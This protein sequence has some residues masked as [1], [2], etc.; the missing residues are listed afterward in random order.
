[1]HWIQQISTLKIDEMSGFWPFVKRVAGCGCLQ[2]Q[3]KH[4]KY[5]IRL[6]ARDKRPH[7]EWYF[8]RSIHLNF[9]NEIKKTL[10][11]FINRKQLRPERDNDNLSAYA[12]DYS[13]SLELLVFLRRSWATGRY[14]ETETS[15][16]KMKKGECNSFQSPPL[17][18]LIVN[19]Q[20][21]FWNNS[22]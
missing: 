3:S 16:A 19:I 2:L 18:T 17:A 7:F 4:D 10:R 1:M 9:F 6:A 12:I 21:I 13:Q 15:V 22:K 5:T 11:K 8:I 14:E 20:N